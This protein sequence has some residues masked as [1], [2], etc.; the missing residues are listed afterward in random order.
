[1]GPSVETAQIVAMPYGAIVKATGGEQN[2]FAEVIYGPN[3]GWASEA[4][5]AAAPQNVQQVQQV[6]QQMFQGAAQQAPAQGQG[7]VGQVLSITGQDVALRSQPLISVPDFG[8]GSNVIVLTNKG[9]TVTTLGPRQNAFTNVS[10]K[11]QSGWMSDRYLTIGNVDVGIVARPQP[12]PAPGPSPMPAQPVVSK[13]QA[14]G[15]GTFVLGLGILL[16][17]GYFAMK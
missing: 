13:T 1:M 17:V 6:A 4:Y 11:G 2:A 12:Q 8:Q 10:Y 7:P 5:L 3:Q 14:A 9:E 16:A 15:S